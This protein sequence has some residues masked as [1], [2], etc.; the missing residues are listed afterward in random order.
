MNFW[1]KGD[2]VLALGSGGAF[3]GVLAAGLPGAI[4]GGLVASIY[5]Y[6]V[7]K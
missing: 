2:Q 3:L 4:I 6:L 7:T 1:K 5:A